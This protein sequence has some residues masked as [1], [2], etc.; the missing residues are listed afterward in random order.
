MGWRSL[1][2]LCVLCSIT[3]ADPAK[4]ADAMFTE[5]RSLAKAGKYEQACA[6][7][8]AALELVHATGT[9]VN[10]ADCYEHLGEI[11]KAFDLFEKVSAESL[12]DGNVER[13]KFARKRADAL[14]PKLP[15]EAP[16]PP[17]PPPPAPP[18]PMTTTAPPPPSPSPPPAPAAS[19]APPP[20][21]AAGPIHAKFSSATLLAWDVMVDG[22]VLCATPCETS[23]APNQKVELL[24]HENDPL[25]LK[26]GE[27]TSPA[28]EI[29]AQPRN[30]KRFY[31]GLSGM[32]LFGLFTAAGVVLFAAGC[33]TDSS[34][35]CTAG[36]IVAVPSAIGFFVSYWIYRSSPPK[37]NVK[38][39]QP[40][41]SPTQVG[42]VTRF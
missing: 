23:V 37:V 28:V 27:L 29:T 34:N 32:G 16:P 4:D 30:D 12:R 26:V 7:F 11:K 14:A 25:H 22:R 8:E 40:Y 41:V 6:R 36:A 42:L 31:A 35:V 13:A 15:K 2:T 24:S 10:L 19:P 18:P 17:P 38:T 1:A 5:G 20:A 39:V 21:P 9:E 3:S 33:A